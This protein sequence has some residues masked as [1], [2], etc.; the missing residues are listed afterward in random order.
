MNLKWCL[1]FYYRTV[2]NS[3]PYFYYDFSLEL[4]LFYKKIQYSYFF[5]VKKPSESYF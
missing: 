3:Y 4:F 1:N 2:N 5:A